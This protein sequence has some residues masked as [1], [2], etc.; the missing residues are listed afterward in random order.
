MTIPGLMMHQPLLTSAI[1]DHAARNHGN[2]EVVS[3]SVEG[4]IHRTTYGAVRKRAAR[5]A[6][7]LRRLGMQPGDR[8]ATLAWNTWRHLE[9]FYAI[10]GI[11]CVCHTINPRLFQDQIAYIANHAGDRLIFV[12]LTFLPMVATICAKLEKPPIVVPLTD[13]AHLPADA[14]PTLLCY[15]ELIAAEPDDI[16]WPQ[17]DENSAAGLCYTSGTTG[18][19]KGA[20]FSHRATVLHALSFLVLK[21]GRLTRSATALVVV[22]MFHV[23]AWGFPF[24][25]A[26]AGTKMVLP[27]PAYDPQSIHALLESEQVT[28]AAG[29]PTVWLMLLQHL[30]ATGA[31][32]NHL[33][34]IVS[35]GAA[36]A[37]AMIQAIE[38]QGVEFL[39]GWGMTELSSGAS[40]TSLTAAH[41]ALPPEQR[42]ARQLKQGQAAF[43]YE[44]KLLDSEGRSV[45]HDGRSQGELVAR[46]NA[47]VRAYFRMPELNDSAF[48]EGGWFRTG[49]VCTIDDEG[50]IQ[51]TDRAKDMIKSGGEWIPSI[52]LEGI[53]MG[54]ATIA[55]AAVI[56]LPHDKWG[57]R[58]LLVVVL[59]PGTQPDKA[60]ILDYLRPRVAKW[61]MPDDVVF[62]ET[63]PLTATGK[64]SKATL[65]AQFKEHRLPA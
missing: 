37:P 36:P 10:A 13:R 44:F 12:D 63:L 54:Q 9:L 49:D 38:A 43:G 25:L 3:R 14:D 24:M 46:G 22:P 17:F 52:E 42:L 19:P 5:A 28:Y 18:N 64:V 47:V 65:R 6:H 2:V 62:V 34:T 39:H 15:E 55:Q 60:A 21:D 32:L 20:L 1:I 50:Y 59:R 30:Q 33:R 56:A 31:K 23:N 7:A 51:V 29:V 58:P 8:V 48:C 41:A 40:I 11:G 45:P 35:G 53:A 4:P 16:D 61:W 27:G 26:L 57:E